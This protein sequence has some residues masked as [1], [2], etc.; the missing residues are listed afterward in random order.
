V[1]DTET[2]DAGRSRRQFMRIT[3]GAVGLGVGSQVL[4]NGPVQESEAVAP[5]VAA[6]YATAAG[7]GGGAAGAA[8]GWAL[9]EFE[10]IGS[11]D[12]PEGET[13]E[14]LHTDVYRAARNRKSDNASTFVDN[15]T[16]LDGV[17]HTAHA[18]GK[19][20]AIEQLNEQETQ[21]NVK[22]SAIDEVNDYETTILTNFFKGW[23]ESVRQLETRMNAVEDHPDIGIH[24]VFQLIISEDDGG[25]PSADGDSDAEYTFPTVEYEMPD[26][27][28]F[29]YDTW[30]FDNAD[31]YYDNCNN[32]SAG[33]TVKPTELN[34]GAGGPVSC[35]PEPVGMRVRGP[36]DDDEPIDY[37][38]TDEWYAIYEKITE[39]FDEVRGGLEKWVDGVYGDVQ[40][41][42]LD[43]DELLTPRE[44]AQLTSEDE[45]FPQAIADLQALNVGVDLERE[46]EIY[47]PDVEAKVWGQLGYSGDDKLETG[48]IDPD[49]KDG[50]IY[51]TYDVSEGAGEWSAYEEGIDGGILTFTSEPF[52]E[53][54][55]YVTTVAA[56]TVELTDNDFEEDDDGEEWTVDLSDDLDDA[57]VDVDHIEYYAETEETQYETIQLQDVFEI[58]T[59]SDSDGEEYD[60]ADFDRSEPHSDDN[61]ITEEEWKEDQERHEELIEKYED[62]QGSGIGFLD[63]EDIPAE[64]VLLIILAILAALFGR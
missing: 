64:G 27:S 16:I 5:V 58:V 60:E 35:D 10:V 14:S 40:A 57:I 18:D 61:Y 26:G 38:K 17:H 7:A 2:G 24:D 1:S 62:A 13:P 42:D 43:V 4:P 20:V 63:G 44:Q 11:D 59:F 39:V 25:E 32:Q 6:G 22:N 36:G 8:V 46:A 56:E 28:T 9:R 49:E 29:E 12:P 51:L 37:L 34:F 54:I 23:Q 48:E 33:D 19:L 53:T 3:A 31:W 52:A 45:D 41:G 55:Y 47:L 30:E 50:A 21:E 15:K